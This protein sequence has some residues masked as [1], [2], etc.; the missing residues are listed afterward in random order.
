M[1]YASL[2]R[3]RGFKFW[4]EKQSS[5][6][7]IGDV[8]HCGNGIFNVPTYT[9]GIRD[10]P[11]NLKGRLWFTRHLFYLYVFSGL[12]CFQ[13]IVLL[14]SETETKIHQICRQKLKKTQPRPRPH[15]IPL[16]VKWTVTNDNFDIFCQSEKTNRV[17][18]A[19]N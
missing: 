17:Y 11:F 19:K 18:R 12:N 6:L 10:C 13:N 16:Q 8:I 9:I 2:W 3:Y 5:R 1:S 15:P 14:I 7:F 4:R